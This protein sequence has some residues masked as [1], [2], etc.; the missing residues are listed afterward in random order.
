MHWPAAPGDPAI[1]II[2]PPVTSRDPTVTNAHDPKLL[3]DPTT[4]QLTTPGDP[5][6]TNVPLCSPNPSIASIQAPRRPYNNKHNQGIAALVPSRQK[7]RHALVGAS[8]PQALVGAG[9]WGAPSSSPMGTFLPC[10]TGA[11][12]G[13]PS[14]STCRC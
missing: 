12:S 1:T 10:R 13:D 5:T 6:I 9:A 7:G 14:P 3:G 4:R 8:T 11:S 2:C